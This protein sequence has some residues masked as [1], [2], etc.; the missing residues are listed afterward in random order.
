MKGNKEGDLYMSQMILTTP[1]LKHLRVLRFCVQRSV[2]RTMTVDSAPPLTSGPI[3]YWQEGVENLER[4]CAG[5]YH[6]TRLGDEFS[7]GRYRVIHK[8]GYGSFSTVWLARDLIANRYVSLKIIA[9][10]VSEL[11]LEKKIRHHLRQGK[12]NHP[13]HNFVLTLL[14]DFWIDGPNGQH[15]CLVS[16][17]VGSHI[18]E[19]KEVAEHEVLPLKTACSI[20]AQLALGLSYIHSHGILHGGQRFPIFVHVR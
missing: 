17:V 3:Y 5:G 20:T 1:F 8:L 13:G 16:E 10:A 4:Y 14:D 7:R 19:A 2:V 11:S 9:A 6:P 12:L 15:Q 18:K